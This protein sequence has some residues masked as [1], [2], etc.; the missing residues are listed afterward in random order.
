MSENMKQKVV[1]K[2]GLRQMEEH[3]QYLK[4]TRTVEVADQIA[5]ARGYGDLSENAEYEEA[6][7]EQ[8]R[9]LTEIADLEDTLRI[10]VVFDESSVSSDR[11]NIGSKVK[12]LYL[13]DDFED[14]YEIVGA[15]E[16]NDI[17]SNKIS[18]ESPVGAALINR[19][20]GDIV[21]V[22]IPNGMIRL[23]ILSIA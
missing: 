9:L 10:C 19:K 8:A 4:T 18:N 16:A 6:K 13:E 20:V 2:E 1:T 22:Q 12:V 23:K 5:I 21:D 3:L 11:V 15:N 14:D 17:D 7:K